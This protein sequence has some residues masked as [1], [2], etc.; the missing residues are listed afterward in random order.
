MAPERTPERPP[1]YPVECEDELV[2]ADGRTVHVRPVV[3]SDV[4]ELARAIEHADPDTLRRRFLGGQPPRT[5]E[6]LLRLVTVDYAR[7]FALAAFAPDG[8]GVGIARYEGE[9]T[10]PAVEVAV[11][12]EQGWRGVGLGTELATRVVR[13]AVELGADRLL[14]DFYADNAR[15]NDLLR[16]AHLPEQRTVDRGIVQDEISLAEVGGS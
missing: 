16:D 6:G 8:T 1:G 3:P 10:W 5:R 7:R 11:V 9:S 15:V 13:R 14:A 4:D 12:V 2:L